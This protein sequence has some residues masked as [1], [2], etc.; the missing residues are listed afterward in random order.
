MT[1]HIDLKALREMRDACFDN[2]NQRASVPLTMAEAKFLAKMMTLL[3]SLLRLAEAAVDINDRGFKLQG[4]TSHQR[5]IE[6]EQ[7]LAPFLPETET[8]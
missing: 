2:A 3:P 5:A 4:P 8:P 1:D 7:A 6:W